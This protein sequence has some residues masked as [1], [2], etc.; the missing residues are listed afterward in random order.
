MPCIQGTKQMKITDIGELD[1]PVLLFGGPYSN[2]HATRA[3]LGEAARRG[4]AADHVICTGDCVAYCAHPVETLGVLREFGCGVVAGNCEKQLASYED[5]C[6][7]GFDTG[8]TCDLLSAGWYAHANRA[9]GRDDRAWMGELPDVITFVHNGLRC[10][11]IHGGVT[12]VSRFI[13]STSGDA[14]VLEE[15]VKL[16]S[17]VGDISCVIAGHSGMAFQRKVEGVE[18]I[19]A[20]VIGMP[21]HNGMPET[22]Y[23]ILREGAFEFH[24][25]TYDNESAAQAM[26]EAG[27]VQGYDRALLSGYWPSE[28]VL[29][30]QLRVGSLARG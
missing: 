16:Q 2:L 6:G 24:K 7:C 30:D 13:W 14:E 11:V 5:N 18:W 26:R 29:P 9:I 22:R 10:G 4:I 20:G 1:A 21:P 25:L 27:L 17:L 8:S 3:V 19:N 28:E 15:L 23:T 12:D